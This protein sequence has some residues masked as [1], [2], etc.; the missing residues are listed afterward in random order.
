MLLCWVHAIGFSD[1]FPPDLFVVFMSNMEAV[2]SKPDDDTEMHDGEEG[3][4]M[5]YDGRTHV[6][7]K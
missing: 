6:V 2:D 7:C 3:M 4:H 1:L 5:A